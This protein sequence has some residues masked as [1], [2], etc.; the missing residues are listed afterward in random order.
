MSYYWLLLLRLFYW[1][2]QRIFHVLI[3]LQM[4]IFLRH[5]MQFWGHPPDAGMV[6]VRS[7]KTMSDVVVIAAR[8]FVNLSFYP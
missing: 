7:E 3:M 5:P 6:Y 8:H 2:Y 4:F 1:D